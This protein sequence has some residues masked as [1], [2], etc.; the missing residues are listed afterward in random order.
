MFSL[1]KLHF[2]RH[3]LLILDMKPLN[4]MER[5][6]ELDQQI[7][8]CNTHIT[9]GQHQVDNCVPIEAYRTGY[10]DQSN[11]VEDASR[12]GDPAGKMSLC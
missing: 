12:A 1:Q 10:S 7:V 6:Y 3:L 9:N 2:A 8:S 5:Y 11:T 4:K